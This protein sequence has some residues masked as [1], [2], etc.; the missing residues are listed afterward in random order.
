MWHSDFFVKHLI[1]LNS[2]SLW[3]IKCG[4][5]ALS[6]LPSNHFSPFVMKLAEILD[7]ANPDLPFNLQLDI[8]SSNITSP[9]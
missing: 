6:Y 3:N 2:I 4:I 8:K 5:V 7:I 9:A 1:D